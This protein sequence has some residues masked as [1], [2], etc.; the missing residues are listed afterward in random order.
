MYS[1]I[2]KLTAAIIVIFLKLFAASYKCTMQFKDRHYTNTAPI[3]AKSRK[4]IIQ[5]NR[6]RQ[7]TILCKRKWKKPNLFRS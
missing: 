4:T 2:A 6:F 3:K 7:F 1:E 5:S